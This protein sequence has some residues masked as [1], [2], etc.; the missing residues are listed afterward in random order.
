MNIEIVSISE[1]PRI[2][3]GWGISF[4]ATINGARITGTAT[5]QHK[6]VDSSE[7]GDFTLRLRFDSKTINKS[8]NYG[9]IR[10]KIIL[11]ILELAR[12]DERLPTFCLGCGL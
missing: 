5:N 10:A 4:T 11:G 6:R 7:S 3:T 2:D 1:H 12:D 8:T 9:E